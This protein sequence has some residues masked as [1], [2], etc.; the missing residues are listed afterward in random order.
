M[1]LAGANSSAEVSGGEALSGIINYFIGNDRS[2][3]V[4]GVVTYGK[5]NYRQVYEGIDLVY[6]GTGRQAEYD[7]VVLRALIQERSL[8][9]FRAPRSASV[10]TAI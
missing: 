6:Y 8:W 1:R 4:Q 10:G 9:I 5:V 2:K 3:W 7:F